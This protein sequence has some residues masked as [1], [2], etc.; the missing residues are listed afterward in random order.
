MPHLHW[1]NISQESVTKHS[2]FGSTK[3]NSTRTKE[4]ATGVLLYQTR[5]LHNQFFIG[6]LWQAATQVHQDLTARNLRR[7]AILPPKPVAR[8]SFVITAM[9]NPLGPLPTTHTRA[10]AITIY[11]RRSL[12]HICRCGPS[13]TPCPCGANCYLCSQRRCALSCL[14]E[15]RSSHVQMRPVLQ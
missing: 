5:G 6:A 8:S 12:Y 13:Q 9:S 1:T 14:H 7:T 11:G 2:Y 3:P 10:A 4:G 15:G